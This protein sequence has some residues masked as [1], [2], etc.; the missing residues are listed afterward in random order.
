MKLPAP[1]LLPPMFLNHQTLMSPNILLV[2]DESAIAEIVMYNLQKEG[3]AVSWE[4][5][6]VKGL[7]RAQSMIPDLCILDNSTADPSHHSIIA[8]SGAD[9]RLV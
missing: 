2:E 3:Y 5:D 6:G 9:G 7:L 4:N 8:P 1:D